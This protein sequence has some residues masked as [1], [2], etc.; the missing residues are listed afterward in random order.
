M[1]YGEKRRKQLYRAKY[2]IHYPSGKKWTEEREFYA[3]SEI[4][5]M[6]YIKWLKS[7]KNDDDLYVYFI[8]GTGK[9]G[10]PE[11]Y[12]DNHCIGER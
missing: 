5:V 6:D 8:K 3:Y 7:I 11:I 10:G 1:S 2:S 12:P 9:F 4:G